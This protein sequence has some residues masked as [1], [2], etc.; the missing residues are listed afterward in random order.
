MFFLMN[1][2]IPCRRLSLVYCTWRNSSSRP[3]LLHGMPLVLACPK[4]GK[5]FVP[6]PKMYHSRRKVCYTKNSWTPH[7]LADCFSFQI[8]L[9]LMQVFNS[10][11]K[12]MNFQ[13]LDT[14]LTLH[15]LWSFALY[16]YVRGSVHTDGIA[17]NAGLSLSHLLHDVCTRVS[18]YYVYGVY[19]T[20]RLKPKHPKWLTSALFKV[21]TH[22]PSVY[23][24][25]DI[26]I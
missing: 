5:V 2:L 18:D 25:F 15:A 23:N 6:L 20:A 19:K 21:S 1:T 16:M 4:D 12:S 8:N 10:L 7:E 17:R 13:N 11:V 24:V 9:P 14:W 22:A 3:L 26:K